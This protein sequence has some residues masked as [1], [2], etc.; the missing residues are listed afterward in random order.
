VQACDRL[1]AASPSTVLYTGCDEVLFDGKGPV[2][3]TL[4]RYAEWQ[5]SD[6][7]NYKAAI[8]HAR[9]KWETTQ[10]KA[11]PSNRPIP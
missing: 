5:G 4:G 9:P 1:S 2:A 10:S 3:A 6:A 7:N 8:A 11:H